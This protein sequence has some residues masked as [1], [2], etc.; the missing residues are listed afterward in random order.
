MA[1]PNNT[2]MSTARREA[3]R[4]KRGPPAAAGRAVADVGLGRAP[5]DDEERAG[6]EGEEGGGGEDE[7]QPGAAAV[8]GGHGGDRS[9]RFAGGLV[10]AQLAVRSGSGRR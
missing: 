8:R 1:N 5:L 6:E 3:L 10:D 9:R 7:E 4:Q 2:R